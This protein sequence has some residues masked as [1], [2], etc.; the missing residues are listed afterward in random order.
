MEKKMTQEQ[1]IVVV[2]GI[3]AIAVI[4]VLG[5]YAKQFGTVA[6]VLTGALESLIPPADRVLA[7]YGD[8]LK[9]VNDLA[10]FLLGQTDEPSDWLVKTMNSPSAIAVLRKLLNYV[11][12]LTDGVP[13][14]EAVK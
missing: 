10:E 4:T 8:E 9:P 7:G 6:T 5:Y 2:L 1:L 12:A 13:S 11:E 3:V 14:D